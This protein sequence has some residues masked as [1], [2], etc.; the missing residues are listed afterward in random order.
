ME[1]KELFLSYFWKKNLQVHRPIGFHY[2][3]FD[4]FLK[5]QNIVKLYYVFKIKNLKKIVVAEKRIKKKYF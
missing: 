5:K 4:M 3:K 2:F 1:K